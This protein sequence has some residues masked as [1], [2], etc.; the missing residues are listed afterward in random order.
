MLGAVFG[1]SNDDNKSDLFLSQWLGFLP[2]QMTSMKRGPPSESAPLLAATPW[3]WRPCPCQGWCPWPTPLPRR[4]CF[5]L[6][7]P[8][9]D[10]FLPSPPLLSSPTPNSLCP[11]S[12]GPPGSLTRPPLMHDLVGT[13]PLAQP[14]PKFDLCIHPKFDSVQCTRIELV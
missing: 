9:P 2:I 14:H 4:P 5:T 11:D 8:Y 3:P 1:W 12:P 10:A 13:F 6:T 7:V